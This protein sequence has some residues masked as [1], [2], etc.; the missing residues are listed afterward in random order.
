MTASYAAGTSAFLA[1]D[2]LLGK[3]QKDLATANYSVAAL[4]AWFPQ[5]VHTLLLRGVN[6]PAVRMHEQRRADGHPHAFTTLVDIFYLGEQVDGTAVGQAFPHLGLEGACQLGVIE[7]TPEGTYRAA[8]SITPYLDAWVLSD[9]DDHLRKGPAPADHVMGIGGATRSLMQAIPHRPV[10]SALEI[11]TGC[12]VVAVTLASLCDRVVATDISPRALAFARANLVIHGITNVQLRL[13][14][15]CEPV[16]GERFD[17]IVSNPPFVIAPV[18]AGEQHVYRSTNEPGDTLLRRFLASAPDHLTDGGVLLSLANWE[19]A[20]GTARDASLVRDLIPEAGVSYTAWVIERGT[21][22]PIEYASLWL[23]DGGVRDDDPQ[24]DQALLSWVEDFSTRRVTEVAFGYLMIR[25]HPGT[26]SVRFEQISG[27]LGEG[28]RFGDAWL[29]ACERWSEAMGADPQELLNVHYHL[30][31]EVE[32]VRTLI[33]GTDDIVSIAFVQRSG[34]ERFESVGT[35]EA[36]FL[37]ACDGELTAAEIAGALADLLDIPA[38]TSA[39]QAVEIIR[40]FTA[41]GMLQP[42]EIE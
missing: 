11:G 1:D 24:Y 33:P 41:K 19:Y 7:P 21:Q 20:W 28:L 31:S 29:Q 34:I 23:R 9:L 4:E 16:E 12:G 25:R 5:D 18:T 39:L 8:L 3:L 14:D 37:G 42:S 13:G 30:S 40:E 32:E 10:G 6:A 35:F 2:S 36:A 17:L 38:K 26:V 27:K 22:T 15:M